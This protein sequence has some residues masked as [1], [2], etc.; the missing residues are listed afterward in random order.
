MFNSHSEEIAAQLDAVTDAGGPRSNR[1]PVSI[2]ISSE[3][4]NCNQRNWIP[5]KNPKCPQPRF[6][7]EKA[8]RAICTEQ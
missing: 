5:K 8:F 4:N 6:A 3:H 1:T 7:D 2:C